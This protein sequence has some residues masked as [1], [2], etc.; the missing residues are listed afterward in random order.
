MA[1]ALNCTVA[2]S[3]PANVSLVDTTVGTSGK[4][5]GTT[6]KDFADFCRTF[7]TFEG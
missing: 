6:L 7:I 5:I 2:H 1:F 3:G 4:I